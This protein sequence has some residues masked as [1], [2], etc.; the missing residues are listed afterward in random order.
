[1]NDVVRQLMRFELSDYIIGDLLHDLISQLEVFEKKETSK[2]KI[3][4]ENG[5][6]D[7]EF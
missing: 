5:F 6:F 2:S 3:L 4:V 7:K 1:M